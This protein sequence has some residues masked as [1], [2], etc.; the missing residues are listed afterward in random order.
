MATHSY[1]PS[2]EDLRA[3]IQAA[4]AAGRELGPD[5]D[6]HLADNVLKKAR[7]GQPSPPVVKSVPGGPS[8]FDSFARMVV[9]LA[10]LTFAGA[11]IL[12]GKIS[13]ENDWWMLFFLWP[14]LGG[15]WWG[16][17][18]HHAYAR[19]SAPVDY[20]ARRRAKIADLEARIERLKTGRDD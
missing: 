14:L 11:L 7:A 15:W 1:S 5:M 9:V 18:R 16:G 8:A 20:E 13:I 6:E 12:M 2:D 3:E 10:V 4:I 19:Y 17:H